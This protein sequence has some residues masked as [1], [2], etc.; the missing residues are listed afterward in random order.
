MNGLRKKIKKMFEGSMEELDNEISSFNQRI[1]E[2][3]AERKEV[4]E[5]L[6]GQRVSEKKI[7]TRYNEIDKKRVLTQQEMQKELDCKQ[8]RADKLKVLCHEINIPI[9]FDIMNSVE[10]ITELL[11]KIQAVLRAEQV[12]ISETIDQHDKE[13]QDRQ[14]K[15]DQLRVELT[16]LQESISSL[17]KQKKV[18]EKESELLEKNILQTER[19]TQQLKIV[20]EKLKQTEE[21]Y[22]ESI[23]KFNQN[24]FR[25]SL[26]NDKEH[27]K[28]LEAQFRKVDER[29]TFLNSISKLTAELTIKEKELEK[30]EEEI[31]KIKSKHSDNFRKVF[32]EG[33]NV[34]SNFQ[35]HLKASYEK[36]RLKIKEQNDKINS[37]KM[38]QQRIEIKRK[39]LKDEIQK[40]E[41]ELEDCKEK[42]FEKCHSVSYE[43]MLTKSKA[44][45]SKYQ[46]E[47]GAQTSAEVFYKNYLQKIE[48]EPYCPL[49]QKCMDNDEV[50]C[51]FLP[52][53]LY[54][55]SFKCLYF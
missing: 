4:E 46:L 43:E 13:D 24:E 34:E 23:S 6:K 55:Y 32:E 22:E 8:K 18:Q 40:S 15:I 2:K 19:A 50:N 20:T 47:H 17:Q 31:R 44:A 11:D 10:G 27:I 33:R 5:T 42:V 29:L 25:E 52:I 16:K 48:E 12:K 3:R 49:C 1:I 9:N 26:Q 39:S 28:Q 41:K 35:R 36:S 38:K 51:S 45:V 30:R 53:S 54:F 14:T 21:C 7:Q 37:L